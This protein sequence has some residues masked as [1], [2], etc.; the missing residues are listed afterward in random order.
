MSRRDELVELGRRGQQVAGLSILVGAITGTAVALFE[1]L[2]ERDGFERL[3]DA[4]LVVQAFAPMLGLV[5]AALTLRWVAGGASGAT[6]EE[7]VRNYHERDERMSLRAVP[8]RLLASAFTLGSGGAMGYEGPSLYMGAAIGSGLQHR[9]SRFFSREDAKLLMVAGVAAGVAAIFK[10]P[11][12]GAI[13]ALEVPYR[14]D[15]ARRMLLPA[16]FSAAAGYVAFVAIAGTAPLFP[17]SGTPP[18]DFRDLGGAACLG[19]ACGIAARLFS[20]MVR[21]MKRWSGRG[22]PAIRIGFA[23]LVFAGAFAVGRVVTGESLVLGSGYASIRW[24]LEPSHAVVAVL[25]VFLIRA[26]ATGAIIGGGGVGGLFIPLVV[27]GAL[28]GR[29]FGGVFNVPDATLFPVLGIAAFL[30][31]GYRVP[32]AAVVF[33]AE[34][35][36]RPGFIVPG[37]IASAASQLVIGK[38]SV[39]AHQ[40]SGRTGHLERRFE[41]P[42]SSALR[43][44]AM[45]VPSDATVAE[46]YG[47]QISEA[48]LR[49]VPVVDGATFIGMVHASDLSQVPRESWDTTLVMDVARTDGPV[50]DVTWTLGDALRAL[51][52]ADEDR[53][54]VLDGDAYLGVVTTGEILKLDEI[55]KATETEEPGT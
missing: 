52:R 38:S 9:L 51:E 40:R 55:L 27:Q 31:A 35:T 34:T 42:I 50:G 43:T 20:W 25:G 18:F 44:D 49:V 19:I 36:G 17:I 12:T 45:T 7:Y 3:L 21:A 11:A 24:A 22:H 37:L 29:A 39:S 16:M 33:V 30:G 26:V 2:V 41:L 4:P 46:L 23:G 13:F 48:R 28:L 15:L 5:A 1:R 8:G 32:L 54:A 10:A 14:D 47:F 53:M 6:T